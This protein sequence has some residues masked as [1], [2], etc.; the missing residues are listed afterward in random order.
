MDERERELLTGMGN[1]YA[2]CGADFESTVE[3]VANA[4]R[5]PPAKV[6]ETLEEIRQRDGASEEYRRLRARLPEGFP[7]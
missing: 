3:M 1:C 7:L 4:R 5:L 6:I 2:A